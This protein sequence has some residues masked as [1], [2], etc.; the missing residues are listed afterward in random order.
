MQSFKDFLA[1]N[2]RTE[3]HLRQTYQ[4]WVTKYCN[5]AQTNAISAQSMADFLHWLSGKY[6]NEQIQHARRA[7]QMY[8]YYRTRYPPKSSIHIVAN[9]PVDWQPRAGSSPSVGQAPAR[10]QLFSVGWD[11]IRDSLVK[12]MRLKHLSPRTEKAYLAWISQFRVFLKEKPCRN[13]AE[14]DLKDFL[15]HLAVE[16]KVA[17]A[18]QRLAFNAILFLFRNALRIEVNGLTTVVASR[19]PKSLPVVLT[20]QEIQRV[21]SHLRRPHLLMA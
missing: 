21:F 3:E 2:D 19:V 13:V 16:K 9:G 15:S 5:Y 14:Q 17:A 6:T 4:S 11:T 12:V 18:T 10:S 20:Q 1:E 8:C 7:L